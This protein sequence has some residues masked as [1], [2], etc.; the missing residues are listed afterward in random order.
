MGRN[1]IKHKSQILCLWFLFCDLS[2]TAAAWMLSHYLR[3]ES[4]LFA[5]KKAPPT[6]EMCW[7]NIPLILLLSLLAYHFTGQYM[8]HRFRRL[9]EEFVSVFM[10]TALMGL[11]VVAVTFG[12]SR[13]RSSKSPPEAMRSPLR[14]TSLAWT[15]LVS[16]STRSAH[17]RPGRSG[18]N[19]SWSGG[20]A[21]ESNRPS[22][23]LCARHRF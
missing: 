4:G 17:A 6:F 11:F 20:S 8:I 7:H 1:M 19:W 13:P 21:A 10:G 12:L 5:V 9:R 16:S 15:R 14:R 3:F 23:H 22:A 18:S 2:L